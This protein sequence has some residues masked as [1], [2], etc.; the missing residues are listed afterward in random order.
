MS[1][2]SVIASSPMRRRLSADGLRRAVGRL[3]KILL[4]PPS[5][6]TD[7]WAD[8]N[9]ELPPGNAEPGRWRSSRT[10]Y[11]IAIVRAFG[12]R[13]VKMVIAVLAGQMGKT[14]NLL[15]VIG[16]RL[17]DDPKPILYIA[18]TQKLSES[19]S[20]DRAMKMF[21]SARA[22][23]E[24]VAKGKQNKITEKWVS[25]VR[26][27]FGWA[28]SATEISSHP[29]ALV[30]VD[31]RD[32]MEDVK[33]EGDPVEMARTRIS[34]YT[35]E[36][37]VGVVST[38]TEGSV[39]VTV[40]EHGF[41]RWGDLDLPDDEAVALAS[42]IWKLWQEGTRHEWAWPC[43][44]CDA[45][46]VPRLKHL[47]I[48]EDATPAR[49]KKEA[50]LACPHCGA[51]IAEE[52]KKRMNERGVFVA[53]GQRIVDGRVVGKAAENEVVSFWV[54][55]LCSP[56]KTFG[57]RARAIVAARRSGSPGRIR[58]VT[59]L[60]FGELYALAGEGPEWRAVLELRE[61]YAS[62]VVP[63]G[64]QVLTC[65]VDVQKNRLV[66][67]VRGWG[68]NSES[69]LIDAGELWGETKYDAVWLELA[70]LLDRDFDGSKIRMMLVDSGYNPSEQDRNPDNQIY[71]F[72]RR[73]RGRAAPSK[74]HDVQ[75]KPF[76][77][78]KIDVSFRGKIFKNGLD[79]WHLDTDYF[80][81]W[82]HARLAWL[83][84]APGGWHLPSDATEDYARQLTAEVRALQGATARWTKVRRANH[85][86]DAETLNVAAA[87]IL[88]LHALPKPA[89]AQEAPDGAEPAQAGEPTAAPVAAPAP[90]VAAQRPAFV[91]RRP[92]FVTG[93]RR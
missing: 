47:L 9:R 87:H 16:H 37:K 44:E 88:R 5:R 63:E 28:G 33:G 57:D 70:G 48:P 35:V 40:D 67:A 74:G 36:G 42:P 21:R 13:G 85:F 2:E 26:L 49:A 76:K 7:E 83:E 51:L 45:F 32:R 80:K 89:S 43:P 69:W 34:T 3:W 68:W 81:S 78:S 62:G 22:L 82:I 56:W 6:T 19:I 86:L 4:P 12:M 46:F 71:T 17:D 1:D 79:L 15:N 66:Y 38:P 92:G 29:A 31:E 14:E 84:G 27:G 59:N 52:S 55:G 10:P 65:G 60:D 64:V 41:E 53:P 18:P 75:E 73:H 11:M 20:S 61:G 58:G 54:S 72:C 93:W 25:G 50:R 30:I 24:K 8:Q 23:W 90:A 39:T 91:P 77:M